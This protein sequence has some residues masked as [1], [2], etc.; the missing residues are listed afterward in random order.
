MLVVAVVLAAVGG[1]EL[2]PHGG[3]PVSHRPA[4]QRSPS[5]RPASVR[6]VHVPCTVSSTLV[7]S[8]GAWWGMYVPEPTAGSLVQAVQ[9][10]EGYLG[11]PLDIVE[12]YHDMSGTTNG[13]FPDHVEKRLARDHLLL[14][15]WAP[16]N[17]SRNTTFKWQEIASGA[18]DQSV[19]V[20][21]AKR[22]KALHRPVFLSFSPE[23]DG[24]TASR[25][26]TP[27]EFVAAWRHIHDVFTQVGAGNVVWVWTT[28]GYLRHAST[29][30][31]LYPGNSYVDWI[32]YDPY[33]FYTCHG[34]HW[35]TFAQTVQ[36]FYH[37]LIAHQLGGKPVMLSEFGSSSD[38]QQPGR[39][40]A[41]YQG[42]GAVVRA[43]PHIKALVQWN[44][45]VP[46]CTLR[47]AD[48]SAAAQAFRQAGLSPYFRQKLP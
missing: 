43:L 35:E 40:T 14:Y 6:P 27:A 10:E 36:P 25:L 19:I 12:M 24:D 48:G 21:E 34:A 11:R 29:I 17:W 44:S 23:A 32:G 13:I 8:C 5:V 18:I 2:W 3:K 37:W 4:S 16:A 33:N 26:G 31:A 39:E 9:A 30:A 15:S 42:I 47:L 45:T 1:Y 22:L 20:P 28:E 38:P 41:W 7:P 46:G